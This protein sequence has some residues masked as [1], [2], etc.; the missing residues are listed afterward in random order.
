[1]SEPS[2]NQRETAYFGEVISTYSRAQVIENGVLVDAG[3]TAREAGFHWP[4]ALTVTAWADRD[5]QEQVHQEQSGRLCDLL[6]MAAPAIRTSRACGDRVLFPLYRVRR[7]GRSR[8]AE[9]T[10]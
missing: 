1:M 6:S 7:D 5:S 8:E 4:L 10:T 2:N 9:P 3:P